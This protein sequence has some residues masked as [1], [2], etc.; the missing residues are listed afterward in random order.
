MQ[1]EII[2]FDEPVAGL[3][4]MGRASVVKMIDDYSK[5]YNATVL[6]I[7]HNMEDMALIAD[8]LLVMNKGELA[9]FDTTENVFRQHEYLKSIGLN[10]P[11]VTQI[12]LLLKEKGI[13]I[14]DNIFT[15]NQA[16][17]Y[18]LNYKNGGSQNA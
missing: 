11:M 9:L 5:K 8:K 15:V 3:D 10:V 2:I 13:D 7:S 1:P 18:L 16:V 17:D 12:M 6:I 14:P 4:P